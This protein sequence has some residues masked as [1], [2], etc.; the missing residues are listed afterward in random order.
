MLLARALSSELAQPAR[1]SV[2]AQTR[3]SRVSHAIRISCR[4][5]KISVVLMSSVSIKRQGEILVVAHQAQVHAVRSGSTRNHV[6]S[7][8]VP[9]WIRP[10]RCINCRHAPDLGAFRQSGTLSG[11]RVAAARAVLLD[12][13]TATRFC[14][15][16]IIVYGASTGYGPPH[17]RGMSQPPVTVTARPPKP[18][19][20]KPAGGSICP[21]IVIAA[22]PKRIC[23][24]EPSIRLPNG[25]GR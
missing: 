11:R 1:S 10:L 7:T 13:V 9:S 17:L 23:S 12:P 16:R 5:R 8:R 24:L 2:P 21:A 19:R 6:E 18:S 3:R 4:R 25:Q 14:P 20:P 15:A 22:R